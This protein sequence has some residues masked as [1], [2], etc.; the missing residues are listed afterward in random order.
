MC[1]PQGN[2]DPLTQSW[3]IFLYFSSN[4]LKFGCSMYILKAQDD[5]AFLVDQVKLTKPKI[6]KSIMQTVPVVI[7]YYLH[8]CKP[9]QFMSIR[10]LETPSDNSVPWILTHI[11]YLGGSILKTCSHAIFIMVSQITK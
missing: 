10:N 2:L 5:T 11:Y 8:T 6:N 4:Q 9:S 1:A 7:T 3:A